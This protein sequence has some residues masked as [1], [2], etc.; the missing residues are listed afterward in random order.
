[1]SPLRTAVEWGF[2]KL[3][4]YFAF[5]NFYANLKICLQPISH[6][7]QTATLL[8]NCHTCCYGSEVAT[9]FDLNPPPHSMST[10][11]DLV[12]LQSFTHFRLMLLQLLWYTQRRI[13]LSLHILFCKTNHG[14]VQFLLQ[15]NVANVIIKGT[16]Q[17][18]TVNCENVQIAFTQ[19]ECHTIFLNNQSAP[20]HLYRSIQLTLLLKSYEQNHH[21]KVTANY[22]TCRYFPS[23]HLMFPTHAK[24]GRQISEVV[25]WGHCH[26]LMFQYLW[27]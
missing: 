15:R 10:C 8:A 11:S 17:M 20:P 24:F 25:A 27:E 22:R 1:M 9:Y 21:R 2:A 6:Y 23:C 19:S 7:F 3:T 5:V 16:E 18:P 4:M 13:V 12:L 26:H 14:W